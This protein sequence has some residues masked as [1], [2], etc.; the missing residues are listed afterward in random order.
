LK[1]KSTRKPILRFKIEYTGLPDILRVKQIEK[2]Y[3]NS[4]AN[5]DKILFFWRRK[6]DKPKTVTDDELFGVMK[7]KRVVKGGHTI[8]E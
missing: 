4:V 3:Y 8:V 5:C 1:L 2:T 7:T 6:E